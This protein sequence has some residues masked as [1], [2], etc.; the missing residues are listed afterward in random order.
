LELLLRQLLLLLA[1]VLV[2]APAAAQTAAPDYRREEAWLCRPGRTDACT[3]RLDA[4]TLTPDGR[5]TPAPFRSATDPAVDCFYVYPTVSNDPGMYSDLNPGPEEARTVLVQAGRFRSVCR[6]FAPNYR[7]V[8]MIG[9]G[10]SVLFGGPDWRTPYGDVRAAWRDY[11]RRDNGGRGVILI[12]H[13]QGAIVLG[14]LLSEE[15]ER[16]PAQRRLLVS[17]VLAGHPGVPVPED[18]QVG[19]ELGVTPLCRSRTQT[20]CAVVFATYADRDGTPGRFFGRTTGRAAAC[21]HPGAP[22]GGTG[23]LR[24]FLPAPA[25]ARPGDPP[26]IEVV[27]QLEA[28][29]RSDP[30][31]SVLRVRALPGPNAEMLERTMAESVFLPSWGLHVLDMPLTQGSLL[32]LVEGQARAWTSRPRLRETN[33]R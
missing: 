3:G 6:L 17:A 10:L 14:Q 26:F 29:C 33:A 28:S 8:T 15:I 19:A 32:E 30:D 25:E 12:G 22:G 9:L 23:P 24:A 18:E 5:R 13:S 1:A 16:D 20:G 21:V 11:L 2:S 7:Q 27:G 4:L 31:G